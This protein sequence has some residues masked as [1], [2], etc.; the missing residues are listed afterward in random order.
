MPGQDSNLCLP[1]ILRFE[2]WPGTPME[3]PLDICNENNFSIFFSG[4]LPGPS[5]TI[6][7]KMVV[8]N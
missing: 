8:T 1:F 6:K 4:Q 3:I 5:V 7:L 2:S